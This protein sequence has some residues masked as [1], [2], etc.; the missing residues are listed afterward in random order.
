ML[1]SEDGA[2][3]VSERLSGETWMQFSRNVFG[4]EMGKWDAGSGP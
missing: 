4:W 1:T 3:S 2:L